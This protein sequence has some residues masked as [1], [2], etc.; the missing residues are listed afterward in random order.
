MNV[1][2]QD[3]MRKKVLTA[4]PH[5]TVEH[6]RAILGRNKVSALPVV[7]SEGR[8]VGIVS[9]T[10][11]V[12]HRNGRT[13]ISRIMTEKVYTVP[14]YEDVS[15]AARIMRNHGIHRVVVTD[16]Q[17]VVGILSAFDLL[18]LVADHRF[19]RKRKPTPSRRKQ[20]RRT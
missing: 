6:V 17:E 1:K 9:T 3:L 19:E 14:R 11:L 4:R 2:V 7:D 13:P 12:G 18:R 10:D 5:Q 15:I 20:T 16:E 8:P